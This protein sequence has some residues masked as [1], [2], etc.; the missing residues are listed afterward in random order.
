MSSHW[1]CMTNLQGHHLHCQSAAGSGY[2]PC[3]H[4]DMYHWY[5]ARL[6]EASWRPAFSTGL[7]HCCG[8]G[9][10]QLAY[11]HFSW[12]IAKH[13]CKCFSEM[14]FAKTVSWLSFSWAYKLQILLCNK[15]SEDLQYMLHS[16]QT[17]RLC[18]S[19]WKHSGRENPRDGNSVICAG[20]QSKRAAALPVGC[21]QCLG[22]SVGCSQGPDRRQPH[23][24]GRE[25]WPVAEMQAILCWLASVAKS[26]PWQ[27]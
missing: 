20:T 21:R 11:H 9:Q 13:T 19:E 7:P 26:N 3:G 8:E 15:L 2:M 12:F 16:V 6:L 22:T 25:E 10:K 14:F 17:P 1:R 27:V 24:F 5:G 18:P 23:G 4:H